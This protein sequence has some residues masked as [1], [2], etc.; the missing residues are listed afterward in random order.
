MAR[1]ARLAFQLLNP[2]ARVQELVVVEAVLLH[3]FFGD[4]RFIA[5]GTAEHPRSLVERRAVLM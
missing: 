3:I 4:R 1:A 5:H 2:L